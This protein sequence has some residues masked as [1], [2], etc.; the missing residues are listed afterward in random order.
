MCFGCI[1]SLIVPCFCCLAVLCACIFVAVAYFARCAF[2]R[3][4][5]FIAPRLELQA[6][7]TCAKLALKKREDKGAYYKR[8]CVA[9]ST[10]ATCAKRRSYLRKTF[11]IGLPL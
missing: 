8:P 3:A 7:A 6:A 2:Y 10:T 9:Q 5:F 4:V 11:S 1:G